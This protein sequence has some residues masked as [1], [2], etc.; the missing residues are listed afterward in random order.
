M[1][2]I[3]PPGQTRTEFNLTELSTRKLLIGVSCTC[4][5]LWA[6]IATTVGI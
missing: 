4:A 1:P 5:I 3:A 6:V 2:S